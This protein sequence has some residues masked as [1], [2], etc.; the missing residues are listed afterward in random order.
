MDSNGT[1]TPSKAQ[2]FL[3]VAESAFEHLP[4][5]AAKASADAETFL[6]SPEGQMLLGFLKG[7]ALK[8]GVSPQEVTASSDLVKAA[9][10]LAQ[11]SASTPAQPAAPPA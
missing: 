6:G 4:E 3:A 10:T 9:M 7:V 8:H 5:E 2:G 1:S 11:A